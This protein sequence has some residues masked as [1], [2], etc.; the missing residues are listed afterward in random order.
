MKKLTLLTTLIFFSV[1]FS[2]T[3]FAGWTKVS[4]NVAGATYYVDFE[5]IKKHD[6]Y[7]Y[8]WYLSDYLK[9]TK[10]GDLSDKT[11]AQGDCKKFR[12]KWLSMSFH[13]ESMGGGEISLTS[14]T[15]DKDWK[16]PPPDSSIET[17]L[18]S[19]CQYAR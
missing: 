14:N 16:Y 17:V 4:T 1:M 7:V 2:S 8:F 9:P 19:V 10:Y 6:G 5:R 11:Y 3:S 18:K 15:P 13:K 12:Y